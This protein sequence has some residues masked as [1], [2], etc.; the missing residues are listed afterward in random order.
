MVGGRPPSCALHLQISLPGSARDPG[1]WFVLAGFV[2]LAALTMS[3]GTSPFGVSPLPA[4]I[5]CHGCCHDGAGKH[6]S[7]CGVMAMQAV[8][9]IWLL[10]C[11]LQLVRTR[12]HPP[13]WPPADHSVSHCT[14]HS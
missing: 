11:Q 7:Q 9:A 1:V 14:L 3:M 6:S 8:W 4:S 2:R 10:Y 12:S 5:A 13:Q